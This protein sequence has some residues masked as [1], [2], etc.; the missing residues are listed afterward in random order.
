MFAPL[1]N[2][3]RLR[4]ST[5][6]EGFLIALQIQSITPR[7]EGFLIALQIQSITPRGGFS[8]LLFPLFKGVLVNFSLVE[9]WLLDKSALP[10]DPLVNFSGWF[11]LLFR[12][13]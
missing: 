1:G 7:R 13:K 9:G 10:C 6:R 3:A 11:V 4:L 12:G 8:F 2:G 5:H